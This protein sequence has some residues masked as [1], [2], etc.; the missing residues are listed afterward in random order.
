MAFYLPQSEESFSKISG[1]GN[2][3]LRRYGKI[4]TEAIKEHAEENHL[5]EKEIP[6]KRAK[7]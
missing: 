6:A 2:E 1:V 5:S 4:F 7:K 3:K